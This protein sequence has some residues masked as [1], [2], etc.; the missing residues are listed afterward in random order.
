MNLKRAILLAERRIEH[1][2]RI[3]RVGERDT[4]QASW[5]RAE[6]KALRLLIDRAE[7]RD[8]N[9]RRWECRATTAC[10]E[11]GLTWKPGCTVLPRIEKELGDNPDG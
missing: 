1:V 9:A 3:L 4:S 11:H 10:V 8:S 5:M 7:Q 6:I 2:E